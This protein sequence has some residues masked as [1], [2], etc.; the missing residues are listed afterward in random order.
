[1]RILIA[2]A[3]LE[4]DGGGPA[5]YA[6]RLAQKLAGHGDTVEIVA[7][8][9]RAHFEGDERYTFSVQ[10]ILRGGRVASRIRFLRALMRSARHADLIYSLDW[11]SVG[12]LVMLAARWRGI[13]YIVRVGGDYV[14][15]Q[16]YLDRTHQPQPLAGF[17][18][19]GTYRSYR[20][21]FFIA[22][23]L[24]SRAAQVVFNTDRQR[25]LY[26][27]FFG[28]KRS[29]VIYNPV[30][31]EQLAGI[32]REYVSKEIVFW[33]RFTAM[34]NIESLV[35][36]FAQARL[37]EEY[38]LVLIGD[39][40]RFETIRTLVAQA[41]IAQRVEMLRETRFPIIM[42]RVKNARAFVLP[43]W[44][45]IS[46]N[47][48]Y[49]ALAIGLP[50]L[51]TKET[52]LPIAAQL[53]QTI[54]PYS[55]NDIA[56]KLELLADDARYE[57]FVHA[58]RTI[59][60]KRSWDEVVQEHMNLF[61][62]VTGSAKTFRV[63]SVGADRSHRGILVRGS[64]AYKR[65]EAYAARF[66]GLDIVGFSLA[67]DG[68]EA[69]REGNL[70]VYPTRSSSKLRFGLDAIRLAKKLP[71]PTV[72]TTQDP[73][74][75]GLAAWRIARHFKVPLHVQV[76]TDFFSPAY[77]QHSY[78]NR[79]RIRIATFVLKR[80]ARIRVASSSIKA[81]LSRGTLGIPIPKAEISRGTLDTNIPISVLPIYVDIESLKHMKLDPALAD[82]FK[83]FR[84]K[85]L[86]VSRLEPEKN[87]GLAL[88]S[89]VASAPNDAC[90]IVVGAGSERAGL[91]LQAKELGV[92]DRIFFESEQPAIRYYPLADLVLV[93]SRYEGYGLVI[94]E[95]LAAG[96]PVLSTDVGVA[97]DAGAIVSNEQRFAA[98]LKQWFE[99]G[100]RSGRL[101]NY[102]YAN[103]D[104]YVRAYCDDIRAC[105]NAELSL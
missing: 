41:G 94:V 50:T 51:V 21:P 105:T 16:Q 59:S 87:V 77:V 33:G 48:V 69:S 101:L 46:P 100:P 70:A 3:I 29:M 81:K 65:Q 57:E 84:T 8:S 39:G 91:E 90:L 7:F 30:P 2:S 42:E 10:R 83:N 103:L 63:L 1:M 26:E 76:H 6:P 95:A 68:F 14:W 17:Y 11:Y 32:H 54:D 43:S 67:S 56:A 28:V 13:P 4:P 24:L 97:R 73:F 98:D 99:N 5:T 80:S 102:P 53:P 72:V 37:P 96:K 104:E 15:E 44:T 9:D 40:P 55:I 19:S 45:D 31:T 35:R 36:A 61:E 23:L 82:R 38:R 92:S 75:T 25:E 18:E 62:H 79:I 34:K 71:R 64:P 52:Y 27:R 85:V 89:F 86:A 60:F 47:Q 66:G 22:R 49:E 12:I 20:I 78:V 58:F 88:S 74:E 93:T